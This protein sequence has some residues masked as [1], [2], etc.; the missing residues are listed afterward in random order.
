MRSPPIPLNVA[1][2]ATAPRLISPRFCLRPLRANTV[3]RK[4]ESKLRAF[5]MRQIKIVRTFFSLA[6][7]AGSIVICQLGRPCALR[8]LGELRRRL[9]SPRRKMDVF[10]SGVTQSSTRCSWLSASRLA[11][12]RSHLRAARLG[13]PLITRNDLISVE[14]VILIACRM[15]QGLLVIKHRAEIAPA[16]KEVK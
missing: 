1:G 5:K 11:E 13:R 10:A 15:G 16:F 8:F 7:I 6:A 14:E 4:Y 3:G 9:I 12:R 2:L